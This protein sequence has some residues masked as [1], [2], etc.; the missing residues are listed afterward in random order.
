MSIPVKAES[1]LTTLQIKERRIK[2]RGWSFK[3]EYTP[4]ISGYCPS[5][6]KI[7]SMTGKYEV[8]TP[9]KLNFVIGQCSVCSTETWKRKG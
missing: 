3:G 4:A 7:Q 2:K 1:E 6:K 9:Y 5:C 8:V